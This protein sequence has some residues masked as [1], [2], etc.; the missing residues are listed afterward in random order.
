MFSGQFYE[1]R[2]SVGERSIKL[3]LET[4][5][6][7]AIKKKVTCTITKETVMCIMHYGKHHL[8]NCKRD[9]HQHNYNKYCHPHICCKNC[10]LHICF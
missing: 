1:K 2:L 9:S 10:H 5:T 8:H 6:Y 3:L 7:L 4:A